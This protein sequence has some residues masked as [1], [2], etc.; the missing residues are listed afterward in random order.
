MY[1]LRL[2]GISIWIPDSS[3]FT[4]LATVL[5]SSTRWANNET[6]SEWNQNSCKTEIQG[7]IKTVAKQKFGVE[8]KQLQNRNSE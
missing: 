1:I 7:R 4:A 5:L 6:F 2:A 8:L 3:T